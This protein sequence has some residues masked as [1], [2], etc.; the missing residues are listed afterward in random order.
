MAETPQPV[1]AVSGLVK[2]YG[3]VTVVDDVSLAVREGECVGIVGESGSGKTTVARMIVG[4][5]A[6]TSGQITCGG[7]DRTTPPKSSREWRI[8]AREVQIVFQDP[9]TSLDRRQSVESTLGETLR[10]HHGGSAKQRGGRLA[11]L[12]DLVGLSS[13]HLQQ[14]PVNLSGGQRQRVAIARALATAPRMLVLDEAVSALDVSIQAQIINLLAD[15]RA[16]TGIAYLFIS[17]DLA[18][19]RQVTQQCVVMHRGVVVE[20]GSTD[21]VLSRPRREYTQLLLSS[22]PRP[23]WKPVRRGSGSAITAGPEK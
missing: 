1:L 6:A 18:V 17:H 8:R 9:Y 22:V 10:I 16:E 15:I 20:R 13:R 23:G 11:E 7:R 4:L 21:D 19:I 3:A 14:R 2:S 12:A 5:T